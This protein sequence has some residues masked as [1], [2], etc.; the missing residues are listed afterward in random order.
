M[1]VRLPAQKHFRA[2]RLRTM[3]GGKFQHV[4]AAVERSTTATLIP[5]KPASATGTGWVNPGTLRQIRNLLIGAVG[6]LL[7]YKY[8]VSQQNPSILSALW[9]PD[10][11]LLCCLLFTPTRWWWV[12]VLL[13]LPVR[14]YF[15][16]P[17]HLSVGLGISGFANDWLKAIFSA[18][19]LRRFARG[20][21]RLDSLYQFGLF[22]CTA[23]V[24]SPALS[25]LGGAAGR[26]S[27]GQPFWD[28]WY[29]W[30][31]S[32]ALVALAVTPTLVYWTGVRPPMRG[33]TAGRYAEALLLASGLL[34]TSY[35]AFGRATDDSVSTVAI[36]YAPVPFLIWAAARFGPIGASTAISVVGIL[37][38]LS[39][40]NGRGPFLA[41]SPADNVVG[42]QLFLLVIAL[43]M[44][45]LS[46]LITERRKAE[47]SLRQAMQELAL[48]EEHLRDNFAQ[49]QKLSAQL[50]NA[51]EDERKNISREL[52][53]GVSQQITSVLLS[54]TGLKRL[55]G[56]PEAG[57]KQLDMALPVLT[58]VADGIRSL[59]RQLHPMVV[60][61]VG[62]SRAL[63]SLCADNGSFRG[64]E[65]E[66]A[67]CDLPP[68]FASDSAIALYRVAQ[69]ALRN[70]AYHSGSKRARVTLAAGVASVQLRITDWGCGFD[71]D[72]AR[73]K[74]GL[75]LISMQE[76][77]QSL[78]GTLRITSRAGSGTEIIAEVPVKTAC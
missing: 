43:P 22:F 38:M 17:L 74:G 78:R 70:A 54:L 27:L 39:T 3:Q 7:A 63:Q 57:K 1:H 49:I 36:L 44:L 40:R 72:R 15:G 62:L 19:I 59:S 25:A 32:C 4:D 21:V 28:V 77:M 10:S 23:V 67:G 33:A 6:I 73:R 8:G 42:M 76:R 45:L 47:E 65:V 46:I 41:A 9:L 30:F 51:H 53:D 68:Q 12:Y 5:G 52:H 64:M 35:A 2:P 31:L 56:L 60:E 37:A 13:S 11:V 14:V 58:Q 16:R 55:P 71:V 50:L 48:G 61:Y 29:R 20:P 24:V 34:L 18:Y 26:I 75:G 66:F 69:E